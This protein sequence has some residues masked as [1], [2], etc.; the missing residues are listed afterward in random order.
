MKETL[1]IL[2]CTDRNFDHVVGLARAARRQNRAVLLFLTHRGVF[3]VLRPE[4][5]ELA[6]LAEI[7]I[8]RV[9]LI[10]NGLAPDG[11]PPSLGPGSLGTQ[12]AHSELIHR[13]DRYISL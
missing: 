11:L 9:S 6:G 5:E 13:S 7:T 1:G 2:V 12:T 8:C 3:L 4:I 10:E